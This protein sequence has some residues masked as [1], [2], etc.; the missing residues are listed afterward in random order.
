MKTKLHICYICAVGLRPASIYS[1][2][3][4]LVSVSPQESRLVDSVGLPVEFLSPPGPTIFSP[5]LL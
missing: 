1:L 2:V 4:S 5:T 3:G